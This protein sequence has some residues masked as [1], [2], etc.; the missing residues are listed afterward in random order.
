[1]KRTAIK[2]GTSQLRSA[3]KKRAVQLLEYS[4]R[5]KAF[6]AAHPFCA[7]CI[8]LLRPPQ[9]ATEIHHKSGRVGAMLNDEKH[10]LGVSR[11][12]H[13]F[14]HSYPSIARALGLLK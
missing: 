3:S 11:E 13:N 8:I 2:R 4:K 1:M 6:L 10:W 7:V 9:L 5:R 12:G 14:L